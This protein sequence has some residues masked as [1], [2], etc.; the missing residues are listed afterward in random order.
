LRLTLLLQFLQQIA[1]TGCDPVKWILETG[2]ELERACDF[3]M[4]LKYYFAGRM[5]FARLKKH[6]QFSQHS[7]RRPE[8]EK[9][10]E[11]LNYEAEF[12]DRY[13]GLLPMTN[14]EASGS[15]A[16]V[17]LALS[18]LFS[19]L[20]PV[21]FCAQAYEKARESVHYQNVVLKRGTMNK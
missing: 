15:F 17:F 20:N 10:W 18:E 6:R 5:F 11:M 7:K 2:K 14:A 4:A 21:L 3:A 12:K 1:K 13:D 8:H 16:H 9:H 19:A